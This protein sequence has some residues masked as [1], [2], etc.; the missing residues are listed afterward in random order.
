MHIQSLYI[1]VL[2][3]L[4]PVKIFNRNVISRTMTLTDSIKAL[5]NNNMKQCSTEPACIRDDSI[6]AK[7]H[8]TSTVYKTVNLTMYL[9]VSP[10]VCIGTATKYRTYREY[11]GL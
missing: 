9:L 1:D 8:S 6:N 4:S 7:A 10:Q 11:F 5:S 2:L 3:L